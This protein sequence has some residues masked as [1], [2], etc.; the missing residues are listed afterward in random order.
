MI[1]ANSIIRNKWFAF[2]VSLIAL[3]LLILTPGCEKETVTLTQTP[4]SKETATPS[5]SSERLTL[6]NNVMEF[7]NRNHPDAAPFITQ[8]ISW[9]EAVDVV[10]VGYS[11]KTY[12]S[13]GW[14]VTVGRAA[15]AEIAYEIRAEYENRIIWLG[16]FKDGIISER[17]Y[18]I[19]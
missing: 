1:K 15:I 7:I 18:T 12:K 8:N 16:I 17:S 5:I 11:G 2:I 13:N 6:L 10:R 14:A 4:E 9:S 3:I 19:K